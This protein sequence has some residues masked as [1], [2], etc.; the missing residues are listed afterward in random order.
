MVIKKDI[1]SLTPYWRLIRHL[2]IHN[3]VELSTFALFSNGVT[4]IHKLLI[5]SILVIVFLFPTTSVS[6][7]LIDIGMFKGVPQDSL[8]YFFDLLP[9]FSIH[10]DNYVVT[11]IDPLQPANANTADARFQISF[12]QR[13]TRSTLPFN[14]YLFITYTQASTWDIYKRS[15]PFR[16]T[17]YNPGIGLGKTLIKDGR[18]RGMSV[19]SLEH[20]SN[21]FADEESRDMNWISAYTQWILNHNFSLEGKAFIPVYLGK[22]TRDV[23]NYK[24]FLNLG[25][26]YIS[27]SHQ[28]RASIQYQK[29]TRNVVSGN[30]IAEAGYMLNDLYNIYLFGQYYNGY[31]ENLLEYKMYTNSI[32]FG[33]CF[34]PDFFSIH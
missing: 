3:C 5:R 16:T 26:N 11:G 25:F 10:K 1:L 22:Y 33:I 28:F 29:T 18:L 32:R 30:L 13:I 12:K 21:G 19:F 2:V 23:F 6:G 4:M 8:R 15:A 34:K 20:M 7:Q 14:F 31:G 9:P 27:P 17:D 24:G